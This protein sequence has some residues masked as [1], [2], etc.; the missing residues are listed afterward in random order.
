MS[1]ATWTNSTTTTGVSGQA[2]RVSA[3]KE[4]VYHREVVVQRGPLAQAYG[5]GLTVQSLHR[6]IMLILRIHSVVLRL[7]KTILTNVVL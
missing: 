4:W 5:D 7:S 1:P 6:M 2:A 3:A